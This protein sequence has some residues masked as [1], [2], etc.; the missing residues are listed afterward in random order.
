MSLRAALLTYAGLIA[1]LALTVFSTMLPLG[2]ANSLV[3]LGVAVTKAA[4]IG[5]IYM[6]LRHS[7]ILISLAVAVLLFWLALMYGVTLT[8]Y[9]TR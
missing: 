7:S 2:P 5:A 6:H 9:L 3:N 4:L 8:D 1:L